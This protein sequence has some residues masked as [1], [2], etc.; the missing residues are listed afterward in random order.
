MFWHEAM[1]P[2]E[3]VPALMLVPMVTR[4]WA[5]PRPSDSFWPT[6]GLVG[7]GLVTSWQAVRTRHAATMGLNVFRNMVVLRCRSCASRQ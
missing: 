7:I 3:Q 5:K 1:F 2:S 4:R 6:I